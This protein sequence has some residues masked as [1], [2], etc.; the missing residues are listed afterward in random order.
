MACVGKRGLCPCAGGWQGC[1]PLPRDLKF[2]RGVG[3]R[4]HHA[5]RGGVVRS[6]LPRLR[7]PSRS[8]T[9]M[10]ARM[11]AHHRI[12]SSCLM[13][14]EQRGRHDP[15]CPWEPRPRPRL[16]WV[17]AGCAWMR[18]R[19][20]RRPFVGLAPSLC[21]RLRTPPPPLVRAH[22]CRCLN[23]QQ[24]CPQLPALTSRAS[25]FP[26]TQLFQ[27]PQQAPTPPQAPVGDGRMC[28]DGIH[29]MRTRCARRTLRGASPLSCTCAHSSL[30]SCALTP[31]QPH[32]A[33][34]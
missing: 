8:R 12:Q 25:S 9:R 10:H 7:L 1:L 13:K 29:W 24:T 14:H 34:A 16:R 28:V 31:C 6:R 22:P 17:M 33:A 23:Q 19:C 32:L 2:L 18:T 20:A 15:S 4:A 3:A 5:A 26:T 30:S 27:Q 11:H 21:R